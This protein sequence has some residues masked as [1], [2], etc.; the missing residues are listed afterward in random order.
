MS[1]NMISFLDRKKAV[2]SLVYNTLS[3]AG[4]LC[5]LNCQEDPDLLDSIADSIYRFLNDGDV[6]DQVID[7]LIEKDPEYF[8]RCLARQDEAVAKTVIA[9]VL[10][11]A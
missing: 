11:E 6:F 2:E 9:L 1:S 5:R 8:G 4:D 10:G 3:V 7:T